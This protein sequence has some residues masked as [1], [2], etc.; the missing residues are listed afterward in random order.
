[1]K[2]TGGDLPS[3]PQLA[4][5]VEALK[6]DLA[7][8]DVAQQGTEERL[9]KLEAQTDVLA[10]AV[11]AIADVPLGIAPTIAAVKSER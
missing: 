7:A 10:E 4:I 5:M 11:I 6:Q 8:A 3:G 2:E 9:A 1:M